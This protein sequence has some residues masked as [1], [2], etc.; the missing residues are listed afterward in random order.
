MKKHHVWLIIV[1]LALGTAVLARAPRPAAAQEAPPAVCS[2]PALDVPGAECAALASFYESTNGAGWTDSTNWLVSPAVCSWHGITCA[3]ESGAQHVAAI[4]LDQNNLIGPLPST[5]S[6]L[7]SLSTL[8]LY[9]NLLGG[10]IPAALGSIPTL[11]YLDLGLN[12]LEGPIPYPLTASSDPMVLYLDGNQLSGVPPADYCTANLTSVTWGHNLLDVYGADPCLSEAG[13]PFSGWELTQTVP[14]LGVHAHVEEISGRGPQEALAADVTVSWTPIT[15]Q[16]GAGGYQVFSG[17]STAGPF[18]DLRATVTDKSASSVTF[19]V[20]GDPQSYV[21]VVRAF[22][23]AAEGMN[24]ST[25]VSLESNT[26]VVGGVAITL[27]DVAAAPPQLYLA[28]LGPLALLLLSL[29]A[30]KRVR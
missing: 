17:S 11:I 23:T 4:N 3:G 10:S 8:D 15:F 27:L 22:T 7:S 16:D 25:L 9:D 1:V 24:K 19:S 21:F 2:D 29:L 26:A 14:P 30:I 13:R 20:E 5:L 28:L 12:L 18:A 6:G